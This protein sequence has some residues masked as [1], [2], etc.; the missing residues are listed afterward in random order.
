MSLFSRARDIIAANVAELLD[1][2]E[3]PAKLVRLI[4][5]EMEE[6]LAEVRADAARTIADQKEIARSLAR[7]RAACDSWTEK[8]ELALA[9]DREDLARAAL[10]EKARA[11][12]LADQL[13]D[14]LAVLEDSLAL[15]EVDILNLES[16]LREA[17]SRQNAISIRTE[18]AGQRRR[19]R[20]LTHGARVETALSQFDLLERRADLAEGAAEAA[21]LGAPVLIGED[22]VSRELAAMK[23]RIGSGGQG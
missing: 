3:D 18:G 21:S 1:R 14:E 20:E 9:R 22:E 2:A 8:A 12:R 15:N 23:A 13:A 10:Q 11:R 5:R 6:T 16:K 4:I 7:A 19:L 17:R